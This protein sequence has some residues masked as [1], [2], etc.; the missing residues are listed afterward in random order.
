MIDPYEK[1]EDTYTNVYIYPAIWRLKET[2]KI[3]AKTIKEGK[4]NP[5]E[6]IMKKK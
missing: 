2:V 5:E 6:R 3:E 1:T 4:S